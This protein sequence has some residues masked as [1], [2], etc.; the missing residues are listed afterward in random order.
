MSAKITL[1]IN[2]E[3][4]KKFNQLCVSLGVTPKLALT[5]FMRDLVL[6]NPHNLSLEALE[7]LIDNFALERSYNQYKA[8]NFKEYHLDA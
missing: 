7:K 8:G 1:E 5:L 3:D 4:F 2:E 6:K